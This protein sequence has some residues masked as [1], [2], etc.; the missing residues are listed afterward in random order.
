MVAAGIIPVGGHAIL[1]DVEATAV[2]VLIDAGD[3]VLGSILKWVDGNYTGAT[4]SGTRQKPY[5]TIQAAHDAATAGDVL[6]IAQ[7]TYLEDLIITKSLSFICYSSPGAG[8]SSNAKV[9]GTATDTTPFIQISANCFFTKINLSHFNA[10][11]TTTGTISCV[12]VTGSSLCEFNQCQ[13]TDFGLYNGGITEAM[14]FEHASSGV[15]TT[16]GCIWDNASFGSAPIYSTIKR[17]GSGRFFSLG[18]QLANLAAGGHPDAAWFRTSVFNTTPD[19]ISNLTYTGGDDDFT[20]VI[21][22]MGSSGKVIINNFANMRGADITIAGGTGSANVIILTRL[23]TDYIKN[24]GLTYNSASV[25]DIET[26]SCRDSTDQFNIVVTATLQANIAASGGGGLDTGA[27]AADTWYAVHVIEGPVTSPAGLLSL[28][29]TAPTLPG[30]FNRF[31][32]V[33]WVRN[34]GSSNFFRFSQLAMGSVRRY[35]WDTA[36]DDMRV[37]NAGSATAFTDVDCSSFV[38]PTCRLAQMNLQFRTGGAGA[39]TDVGRTRE[40]GFSN[41]G[42]RR[43]RAGVVSATGIKFDIEQTLN[44]SQLLQYRVVDGANNTMSLRITG[45][46]EQV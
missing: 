14:F 12:K 13:F 8:A 5:K 25:V 11:G 35:E 27:E 23:P 20:L 22:S 36:Q 10:S 41:A 30:T 18:D 15:I 17:T 7:D 28:S 2:Q 29:S 39:A 32:H 24:I 43:Y 46:S 21:N 19:E 44:A 1:D 42:A 40:K 26:G 37:L 9:Q 34:D 6:M 16:R 4:E 33:G 31:R 38:P 3:A 45:F